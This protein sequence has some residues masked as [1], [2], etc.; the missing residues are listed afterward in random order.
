V[1]R[2]PA[3]FRSMTSS[4]RDEW[5]TELQYR[6]NGRG[7]I[8]RQGAPSGRAHRRNDLARFGIPG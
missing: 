7:L 6:K 1:E 3:A 4:Q 5:Y 2:L 8:G